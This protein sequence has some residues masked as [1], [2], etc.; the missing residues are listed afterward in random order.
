MCTY[1]WDYRIE[2][3]PYDKVVSVLEAFFASYPKGD[4][5]C[6]HRE[7]YKLTFRRGQW[8][9][10]W[11]GLGSVVPDR[12]VKGDFTQWPVLVHILARPSPEVFTIS[13]RYE[14]HLPSPMRELKPEVQSS[15][16]Q[17]IEKELSDLSDYLAECADLDEPP[18]AKPV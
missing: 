18:P 17:Y 8:K 13:I 10:S 11:F 15:V 2:M 7:R 6:E 14:L 5:N 12:L 4:Y 1:S 16:A 9:R 3:K